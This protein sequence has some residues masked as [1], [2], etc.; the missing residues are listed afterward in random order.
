MILTKPYILKLIKKKQI[1]IT[2]FKE[3]NLGPASYDITLDNKI[4]VFNKKTIICNEK[5]NY[6]NYTKLKTIKKSITLKPGD[7]ILGIT[8]ERIKLPNNICAFLSGRTKFARLGLAVHVTA[9]FI[10]PDTNNKQVFEIK[11]LSNQPIKL[12]PGT[13]IC[14]IIFQKTK[15]K[16][17]N[18]GKF[19][20]ETSF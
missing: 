5:V 13:K 2:N 4:R 17:K 20:K 18:T 1:I 14:Q 10:N 7:F 6:K 16:A 11:N 15:G 12:F 19:T 3:S 8:K 9:N